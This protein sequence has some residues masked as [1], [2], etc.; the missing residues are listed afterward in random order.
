MKNKTR[1]IAQ[2]GPDMVLIQQY[3]PNLLEGWYLNDDVYYY[4]S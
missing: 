4:F 3:I 2:T 1:L